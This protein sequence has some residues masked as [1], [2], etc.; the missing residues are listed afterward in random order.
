MGEA[1]KVV[2]R[3]L[4]SCGENY[5]TSAC[6]TLDNTS[7]ARYVES[8]PM[9]KWLKILLV[10]AYEAEYGLSAD[11]QSSLNLIDMISTSLDKFEIFGDSDERYKIQG[12]SQRLINS[13]KDSIG[14]NVQNSKKLVSLRSTTQ[15]VK[16]SFADGTTVDCDYAILAIPFTALRDVKIDIV[17]M[18][19]DKKRCIEELGYGK[20]CKM[21]LSTANRNW[22]KDGSSGYLVNETIQNGWDGTQGQT[23][24][25]GPGSYTVY[26]GAPAL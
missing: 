7:L 18:T 15:S 9:P 14:Q 8:L 22:R 12:G 16:L 1:S 11:E 23:N 4:E 3:D 26:L 20:N 24:N 19:D 10:S 21:I 2:A 5:D 13:L 6:E 25:Q 17:D